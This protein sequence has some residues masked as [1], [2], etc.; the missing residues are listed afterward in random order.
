MEPIEEELRDEQQS[1]VYGEGGGGRGWSRQA[2]ESPNCT[3][4]TP[5]IYLGQPASLSTA[6]TLWGVK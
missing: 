5:F 1:P 3:E 4:H 2:R 6:C